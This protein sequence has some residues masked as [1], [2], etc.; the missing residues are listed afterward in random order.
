MMITN[1]VSLKLANYPPISLK[2]LSQKFIKLASVSASQSP[3]KLLFG[4]EGRDWY[5]AAINSFSSVPYR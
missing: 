1:S 3:H 4:M 2:G 5:E